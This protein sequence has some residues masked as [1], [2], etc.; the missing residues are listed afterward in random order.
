MGRRNE[1][2]VLVGVEERGSG[3]VALAADPGHGAC[4]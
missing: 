3:V 4:L 1:G 2:L